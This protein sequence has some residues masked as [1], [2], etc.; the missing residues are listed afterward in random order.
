MTDTNTI[1]R[2]VARLSGLPNELLTEDQLLSDLLVDSFAIVDL[3]IAMQEEFE[4]VF[5]QQDLV[6]LQTVGDL[7]GLVESKLEVLV[8]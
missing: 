1:K 5:M 2:S 3:S 6:D 7:V 8:E 4:I